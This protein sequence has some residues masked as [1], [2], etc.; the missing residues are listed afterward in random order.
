VVR[1]TAS[2]DSVA[3]SDFK[4]WYTLHTYTAFDVQHLKEFSLVQLDVYKHP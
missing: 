3:E 1:A 2:F 4:S